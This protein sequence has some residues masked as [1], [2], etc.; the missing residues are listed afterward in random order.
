MKLV[1]LSNLPIRLS[2]PKGQFSSVRPT[3]THVIKPKSGAQYTSLVLSRINAMYCSTR[4]LSVQ[5][6]GINVKAYCVSGAMPKSDESVA[7]AMLETCQRVDWS[8]CPRLERESLCQTNMRT[9]SHRVSTQNGT[10]QCHDSTNN[11]WRRETK[12]RWRRPSHRMPGLNVGNIPPW[13][14]KNTCI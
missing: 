5:M 6:A 1:L 12:A 2:T 11:I 10:G 9:V 7:R 4:N 14:L 13:R 3:M 8:T